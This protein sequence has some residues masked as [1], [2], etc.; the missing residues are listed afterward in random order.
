MSST[1]IPWELPLGSF[2]A[3]GPVILREGEHGQ[4][5][6]LDREQKSEGV[7]PWMIPGGRV[8]NL[9]E[10]MIPEQEKLRGT[11]IREVKEEVGID[12]EIIRPL[13]TFVKVVESSDGSKRIA[14]LAHYLAR[15]IGGE[16]KVGEGVVE[17]GWFPVS[18]LPECMENV[19][20]V[21]EYYL[22]E[23]K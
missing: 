19:R 15:Q 12:I 22:R 11:C 9:L 14:V 10:K 23:K 5:I 3:S 21:L 4:E 2:I 1:A 16:L 7:T 20:W 8:E 18:K 13:D 17:Y 6:L